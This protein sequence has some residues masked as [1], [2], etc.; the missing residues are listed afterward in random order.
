MG[1]QLMKKIIK[2]INTEFNKNK[3]YFIFVTIL[4]IIG[5][6]AGSFFITILSSDD[7]KLV[8]ETISNFFMKIKNNKVDSIY[9]LRT[10]LSTN[11]LYVIFIWLLGVS[12]IGIPIIIFLVF[13]KSFVLG[14]SLSG[15]IYQY[16]LKGTLLSLGYIFPHQIINLVVISFIGLYALKVSISLIKLIISK[17]Q[18]NF[19]I[20]M[21]KYLG[22]LI[23]CIVLG[24]ISSLFESFFCIYIIKLL[25]FLIK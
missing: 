13:I 19:K 9:S 8:G 12:I 20:I 21:K 14:F 16:K 10:S 6:V 24:L 2:L 23:I 25:S 4:L 3:K 15:I 11:L 7:K 22:A 17:K 5:F 18:I 1:E